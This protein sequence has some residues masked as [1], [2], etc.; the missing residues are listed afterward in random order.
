MG[1]TASLLADHVTFRCEAVDRL[2]VNGYVRSLQFPAGVVAFLLQRGYRIPSPAGLGH[3]HDRFVADLDAY[4]AEHDLP[5]VRFKK[6]QSKEEVARPYLAEAER[7]RREGVV[8]IGTAQE[9]VAGWRGWKDGGPAGHPHFSYG[10]QALFVNHYYC[11]LFDA[12][13]GPSFLKLCPYAP[14]P[15]WAWLNGHEWLKRQ[16]TK[17]SV[18][19]RPLDNGLASVADEALAHRLSA[20]LG[21]GHVRG[22]FERWLAR[23]P[24]ALTDTD[25]RGGFHYDFSIRQMEIS[26][27]A[28]FD[29]PAAGRAWFEGAIRDHLDLGR[30]EQVSLVVNRRIRSSGPRP[31]PGR[32]ETRIITR[33]VDPQL[34][35]RYRSSKVKAYFKE[36]RAL[37]V[38]T[39]INDPNDFGVGRSLTTE[40]WHALRRVGKSVNVRFLSALGE[41]EPR[42]P[43]ATTLEAVV[44]PSITDGLRVPGLRLGDPR[45]TAL[46]AS[47]ACFAHVVGGLTNAGL[48]RLMT[49]LYDPG[50]NTRRATYDLTRL[51]RK[52]FIE[53]VPGS[54]VYRITRRGRDLATFLTKLISR[55]VVPTLD[56]FD[57]LPQPR[58]PASSPLTSAW[59][60]YEH[61]LDAL[62]RR[63]GLAV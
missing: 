59:R 56:E 49:G 38:E 4:A 41:G 39:T 61:Q 48:C 36:Q 13:W 34:Q 43:D 9:K 19:F 47:I 52:G 1:T 25:R 26:D 5:V 28:V 40:H 33:D 2:L 53:R 10:R 12:E 42:A 27:T 14:Y 17:A 8:L 45:V 58:S 24:S 57:R 15:V 16:L 30:P 18:D 29:R 21:A 35:I 46:L 23:L 63:S 60:G 32:F 31:T 7:S 50:Y 62:I 55:S 20:R 11:Y 54:H 3:N 37:R 44:L 51:R 6:R 22:F